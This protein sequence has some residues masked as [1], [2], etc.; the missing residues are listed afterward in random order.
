MHSSLFSSKCSCYK[1][2]QH[3][4]VRFLATGSDIAYIDLTLHLDTHSREFSLGG[5]LE[6]VNP[7]LLGGEGGGGW[8][9]AMLILIA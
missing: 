8:K 1:N 4:A 7:I 9:V 2:G 5:C 6:G 3:I